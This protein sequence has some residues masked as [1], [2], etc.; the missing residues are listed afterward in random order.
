MK[1][2]K[3]LRFTCWCTAIM[4]LTLLQRRLAKSHG[5]GNVAAARLSSGTGVP[6]SDGSS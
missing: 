1:Q 5:D 3:V 6:R 2:Q 4:L